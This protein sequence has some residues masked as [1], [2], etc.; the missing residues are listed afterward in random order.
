MEMMSIDNFQEL[1]GAMEEAKK[2][3]T[4]YMGIV[5]DEIHV[6]GDPNKTEIAPADYT[7]LFAFPNTQEWKSRA[8]NAGDKIGK[9]TSDGRYFLSQRTYKNVYIS[10]RNVGSAITALTQLEQFMYQ[11]QEDGELREFTYEETVALM[12]TLNGEISDLTYDLVGAVLRVPYDE[13]EWML[14][15]NTFENAVK[16]VINNPS[17][18]N[19]ADLFFGLLPGK[20]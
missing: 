1:K 17:T 8:Q 19:E 9:T 20:E 6:Q 16:I 3:D 11:V 15:A 18:V 2:D 14:P 5:D 12:T 7:V 4:P 10:P 13:R